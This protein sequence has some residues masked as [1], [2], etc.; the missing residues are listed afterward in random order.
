M[1]AHWHYLVFQVTSY[2]SQCLP[3]PTNYFFANRTQTKR[4]H[5]RAHTQAPSSEHSEFT[6]KELFTLH[7]VFEKFSDERIIHR[8]RVH[9]LD[10]GLSSLLR[11]LGVNPLPMQLLELKRQYGDDNLWIHYDEYSVPPLTLT[12]FFI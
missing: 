4:T 10:R 11:A 5:T 1:R 7:W 12:C 6:D 3:V 9:V 2:V 8:N